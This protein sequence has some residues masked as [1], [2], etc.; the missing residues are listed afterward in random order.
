VKGAPYRPLHDPYLTAPLTATML[1]FVNAMPTGL[2][3][4][5]KSRIA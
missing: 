2:N 4:T 5:A 1:V 3:A